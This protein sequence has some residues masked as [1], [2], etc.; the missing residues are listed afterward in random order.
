[1]VG[2]FSRA[3]GLEE[4]EEIMKQVLEIAEEQFW[5]MGI[6]LP[7]NGFG[8]VKNNF[9]NVPPVMPGAWSYPTPAPTNPEQYFI[10]GE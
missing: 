9:H 5:V 3:A 4:Q 10:T 2:R 6:S 7:T 8:I 1:M